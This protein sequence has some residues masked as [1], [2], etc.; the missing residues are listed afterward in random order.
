MCR[1]R[2][3]VRVSRQVILSLI[4]AT[5]LLRADSCG[6]YG[7]PDWSLS[8]RSEI[9]RVDL[10]TPGSTETL[11]ATASWA[12]GS[13]PTDAS[14]H[15]S[16]CVETSSIDPSD[17][18]V[19]VELSFAGAGD[20]AEP[21][22]YQLGTAGDWCRDFVLDVTGADLATDD[23]NVPLQ[24]SGGVCRV[25]LEIDALSFSDGPATAQIAVRATLSG[26]GDDPGA[27]AAFAVDLR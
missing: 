20:T 14:P 5:P 4:A 1:G 22:A 11:L 10:A 16:F 18:T 25:E 17:A 9:A 23:A 13:I 8:G 26:D 19:V 15:G 2:T 7:G 27:G 6:G 3:G 21:I 12:E 24:C